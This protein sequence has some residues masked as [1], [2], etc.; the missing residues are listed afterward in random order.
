MRHRILGHVCD[1]L[2]FS[3]F[4]S[5][6]NPR[7][8]VADRYPSAEV[9]GV[10]LSPI[11]PS[12]VPPN[13]RFEVDDFLLPWT[14]P[15]SK[16]DLVHV[17]FL[18]GCI[19]NWTEFFKEALIHVK[20]G[21]WIQNSE[22]S[23]QVLCDDGSLHADAPASSWHRKFEE[24]SAKTGKTFD[25]GRHAAA[26]MKDAGFVNVHTETIKVPIGTWPS[27]PKLKNWG[28]WNRLFLLQGLEGFAMR[29]LTDWA[30]VRISCQHRP[31]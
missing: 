10:D 13:C 1:F 19:P 24:V 22:L 8:E 30:G 17:R 25:V 16:F 6:A 14:F 9:V 15:E 31:P 21:G 5:P 2:I 18:T 7:S 11:Q 3:D 29:G 20:P 27:N 4:V 26:E 23:A 12:F 28:A